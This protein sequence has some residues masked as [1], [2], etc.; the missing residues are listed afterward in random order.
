MKTSP[1]PDSFPERMLRLVHIF[2]VALTI[3][4][5]LIL[6][7]HAANSQSLDVVIVMDSSG[8]MKK[9]DPRELRKSA[10]KLLVSLLGKED[11]ASIVSFSDQGYP[12]IYLTETRG[13]LNRS[14][15]FSA[16]EKISSRGAYTNIAAA[17]ETAARVSRQNARHDVRRLI[18]LMSDGKM[19]LGRDDISRDATRR[20][21]KDIVPALKQEGIELHTIAFSDQSDRRLLENIAGLGGGFFNIANTDKD[22]HGV[23]AAIF[24]QNKQPDILPFAGE[25]FHIDASIK[26][27]TIV[28]SKKNG[29][30]IVRLHTPSNL[31]GTYLEPLRN[32]KWLQTQYFDLITIDAPEPGTWRIEPG[33]ETN[34]AYIITDL[35]LQLETGPAEPKR[36]DVLNV[37]TW[38]EDQGTVINKQEIMSNLETNLVHQNPR[39]ETSRVPLHGAGG[40]EGALTGKFFANLEFKEYGRYT[41]EMTAMTPTFERRKT[42]TFDVTPPLDPE[43]V[44]QTLESPDKGGI[45][46]LPQINPVEATKEEVAPA[47]SA[48]PVEKKKT[49]EVEKEE[50]SEESGGSSIILWVSIVI[51]LIAVAGGAGG[52]VY[53]IQRKKKAAKNTEQSAPAEDKKKGGSSEEPEKNDEKAKPEE[54]EKL[55]AP[56]IEEPQPLIEDKPVPEPEPESKPDSD[57]KKE[58]LD[59]ILFEEMSED[60]SNTIVNELEKIL[61]EDKKP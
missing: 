25:K 34:K 26:E 23:F 45:I 11:R 56:E 2:I 17:V 54:N 32:S 5:S 15:I 59:D 33:D 12:V 53:F 29:T 38:L 39:G 60:S 30:E 18:V 27:V 24:E 10:A 4:S 58:N 20:L 43:K 37:L 6:P 13:D 7:A 21:V 40:M 1:N 35:K 28:A 8:S 16:I 22:L 47:E 41:L 9:T 48:L 14:Q 3:S 46:A 36:G 52:A 57:E 31:G 50:V 49:G 51:A 44:L 61:S 55:Q 42:K 19:D